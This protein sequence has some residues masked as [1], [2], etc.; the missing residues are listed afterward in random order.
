MIT[1]DENELKTNWQS[2]FKINN[3]D[4]SYNSKKSALCHYIGVGIVNGT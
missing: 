4:G 1:S 2:I 3:C